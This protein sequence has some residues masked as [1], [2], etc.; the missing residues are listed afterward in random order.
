MP[1][2][3][4]T[5][6]GPYE[7]T[8]MLG[9]G[10][11][12]EVYRA[13]DTRLG[14]DV[15][16]KVLPPQVERDPDALLRLAR[17]ARLLAS[18][19]HPNIGAVHGWEE[20]SGVHAIVLELIE[21]PTLRDRV[22]AGPLPIDEALKIARQIADAL[23]AAHEQGIIHRDLKPANIKIRPDGRVKVLDF[24]LAKALTPPGG[25]AET[26]A[27]ATQPGLIVGTPAYMSPEQARG[28]PV[29]RSAD[30]WAF[31]VVI[32]EMLTGRHPFISGSTTDTLAAVLRATP[33]W[34]ALPR[35]TPEPVIRLLQRCLEK[36]PRARLRDIGDARL[37][38]EEARASLSGA[39]SGA[40]R[41]AA[42][43]AG[44]PRSS[45]MRK[46]A[47]GVA[48]LLLIVA[49]AAG[50]YVVGRSRSAPAATEARLALV[51]PKTKQF[52]ST[53]AV[54]PDGRS[55]VFV[56]ENSDGKDR[57]LWLRQLS[58]TDARVLP[59]TNDAENPFWSPD[60]KWIAFFAR[61]EGKLKRLRADGDGA[62][63]AICGAPAGRG[64]TWLDDR[65]I[66]FNADAN[67]PLYR[68]P[69][70]GGTPTVL[71]TLD[72][73]R[74]EKDHRWPSWIPGG[75]L[76]YFVWTGQSTS[77]LRLVS[78]AAPDK[79]LAFFPGYSAGEYANG[80]LFSTHDDHWLRARRM[81]LPSGELT[82]DEITIAQSRTGE[83]LG[84][85]A[86]SSSPSGVIANFGPTEQVAQF[87]VVSRD[88]RVL[89]AIG[90][91]VAGQSGVELGPND[92]EFVTRRGQDKDSWLWAIDATT[93]TARVVTK[94]P[95]THNLWS[96]STIAF[97]HQ[98]PPPSAT[99]FAI[100]TVPASGATPSSILLSRPMALVKPVACTPDGKTFVWLETRVP[101]VDIW[102]MPVSDPSTPALYLQD[103][104]SHPEARLSRDGHWIAYTSDVSGSLE[105]YVESFPE[106]GPARRISLHGGRFPRWRAD[107]QEL[108]YEA[109][110][111]LM[112][113]A[114]MPGSPPAFGIPEVRFE[115]KLVTNPNPIT[116]GAYEY[117]VS[118]DGTK[119]IVNRVV[120]ENVPTLD[121]ITNWKGG[122]S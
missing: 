46:I 119:F 21:G 101:A 69:E 63:T 85:D 66:V 122:G 36:D 114:V 64:G 120:G 102:T 13:R 112:S 4:G 84:R 8:G 97:L 7:I 89:G 25:A 92:Q 1:L 43:L 6:L 118:K 53:A 35:K 86:W 78:L 18:L 61:T 108:Y 10:G 115:M 76:L 33:D 16:L 38:I 26:T 17:E 75:Y 31:G 74:D 117:D 68:V 113:V 59:G 91:S 28:E 121:V 23:D 100:M 40:R 42:D 99:Q 96:G 55:I 109:G 19:D 83:L 24:G 29:T 32:Y 45:T 3:P 11:M 44:A 49:A 65:T 79:A 67:G 88:G 77:G 48:V 34:D 94:S 105:V 95:G 39:S 62:P 72:R 93:G 110:A 56:A 103:G 58:S 9:A 14:R 73:T 111:T 104:S 54:S 47:I 2:N 30:V 90:E 27:S 41:A 37:D 106:P 82:G 87:T 52:A 116:Y 70:A 5:R 107:G 57:M 71:T 60:G 15:A 51:P 80:L 22:L 50:A 81:H 98:E 12:G 20:S